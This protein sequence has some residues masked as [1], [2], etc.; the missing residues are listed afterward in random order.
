MRCERLEHS[1]AALC[2]IA[3]CIRTLLGPQITLK[4][5]S[6]TSREDELLTGDPLTF[7]D[8]LD[9]CH[10]AGAL[11]IEAC[12]GLMSSHGCGSTTFVCLTGELAQAARM[13]QQQVE[14]QHRTT[15]CACLLTRVCRTLP[16]ALGC[17][18]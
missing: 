7:L 18:R 16:R 4:M 11:L 6:A 13:L 8:R 12:E 17:T 10:P 3:C 5:A 2:S 15:V 14:T 9:V 1:V